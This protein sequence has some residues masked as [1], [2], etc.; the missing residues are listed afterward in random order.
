MAG[1]IQSALINIIELFAIMRVG[2][3]TNVDINSCFEIAGCCTRSHALLSGSAFLKQRN[4]YRVPLS[5][6][7]LD[8]KDDLFDRSG[9]PLTP[10]ATYVFDD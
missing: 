6:D 3:E 2:P 5:L 8:V 9:V 7:R 1:E 4:Y 10:L